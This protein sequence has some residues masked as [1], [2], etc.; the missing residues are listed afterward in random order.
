MTHE[1]YHFPKC[2]LS[3]ANRVTVHR[4]RSSRPLSAPRGKPKDP[5]IGLRVKC[6]RCGAILVTRE[7]RR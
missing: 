2:D 7:R 6:A 1:T 5:R 3:F 4:D